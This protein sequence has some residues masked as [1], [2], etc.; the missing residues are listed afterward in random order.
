MDDLTSTTNLLPDDKVVQ[1]GMWYNLE[2]AQNTTHL[3]NTAKSEVRLNSYT[4]LP[5]KT[6]GD[7]LMLLLLHKSYC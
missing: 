5:E 3:L 4:F 2:R 7:R 1:G 6:P